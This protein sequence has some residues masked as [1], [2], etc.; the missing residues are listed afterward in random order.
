VA[1]DRYSRDEIVGEIIYPLCG[2]SDDLAE[3]DRQISVCLDLVS[4]SSKVPV[5]IFYIIHNYIIVSKHRR[6]WRITHIVVL[7]AGNKQ[8]HRRCSQG[9]KSTEIRYHRTG[10]FV[11]FELL[12]SR[13]GAKYTTDKC[14]HGAFSVVCTI[15]S[16]LPYTF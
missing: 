8:G 6:S 11:R 10:G 12:L 1:F 14:N 3:P 15:L 2:I 4:R 16:V 5:S 7:S 13:H 9:K